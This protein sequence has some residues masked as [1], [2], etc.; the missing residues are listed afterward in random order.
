MKWI[1][2][3]LVLI[4]TSCN[5]DSEKGV[6]LTD[7]DFK[8]GDDTEIFFK[9]VRQSYYDLEE[10]KTAN[11]N[12]FR[13]ED[14]VKESAHPVLN[15]AIVFNYLQDEATL[16]IEPLNLT[17]E[18]SLEVITYQDEQQGDTLTLSSFNRSAMLTFINDIYQHMLKGNKF[19]IKT[20]RGYEE[21]LSTKQEREAF[22]LTVSDYYRLTRIY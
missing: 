19:K 8:T 5:I 14:R 22:R 21:L 20:E 7:F 1:S 11:L 18:D 6:D 15:L 12:I 4:I 10:N 16:L 3:I 9:N 17:L 2:I 13:F